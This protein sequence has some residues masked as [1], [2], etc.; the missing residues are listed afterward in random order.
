MITLSF[1][2]ALGVSDLMQL[3]KELGNNVS[4]NDGATLPPFLRGY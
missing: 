1:P 2:A 4:Y 3:M